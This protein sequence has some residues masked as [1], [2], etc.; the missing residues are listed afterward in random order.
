M[1]ACGPK[2]DLRVCPNGSNTLLRYTL[3]MTE[4][5]KCGGLLA[6]KFGRFQTLRNSSQQHSTTFC[7]KGRNI[8]HPPILGFVGQQCCVRLYEAY[9]RRCTFLADQRDN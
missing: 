9:I 6:Q 7:A 5:E 2:S 4:Q 8:Q 3:E 1:R